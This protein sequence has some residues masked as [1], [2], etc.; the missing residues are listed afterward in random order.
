VRIVK[1]RIMTVINIALIIFLP[2]LIFLLANTMHACSG[3]DSIVYGPVVT[4][5]PICERSSNLF[6]AGV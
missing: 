2:V 1:A 5:A 3:V 4:F 6:E